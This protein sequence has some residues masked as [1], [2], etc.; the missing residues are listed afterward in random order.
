MMEDGRSKMEDVT[1]RPTHRLSSC[2]LSPISLLVPHSPHKYSDTAFRL[3]NCYVLII[4]S[5]KAFSGFL[6]SNKAFTLKVCL[7]DGITCFRVIGSDTRSR[8]Q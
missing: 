6:Q 5:K 2:T 4:L 7:A 1:F 8:P 3:Y